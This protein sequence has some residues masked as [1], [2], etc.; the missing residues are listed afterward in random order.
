MKSKEFIIESVSANKIVAYVNSIHPASE[1]TD[2]LDRLIL[3]FSEYVLKTVPVSSLQIDADDPHG[4]VIYID[5][6]Y[7]GDITP[8]D[9]SRNPIV[10]DQQGHILDGNHRAWRARE[11]G[12]D[13]ISAYV[14]SA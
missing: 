2:T 13:T 11:V 12:L 1:Q 6:D 8:E 4:R 10:I 9:I 14:G 3:S 7:A 5:T